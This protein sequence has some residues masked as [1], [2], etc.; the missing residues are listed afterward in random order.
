LLRVPEQ[1]FLTGWQK[2]SPP[3]AGQENHPDPS[4]RRLGDPGGPRKAAGFPRLV[5]DRGPAGPFPQAHRRS[6]PDPAGAVRGLWPPA[7]PWHGYRA[8]GAMAPA[9]PCRARRRKGFLFSCQQPMRLPLFQH[10]GYT[11]ST[12]FRC[13]RMISTPASPFSAVARGAVS[14]HQPRF[15]PSRPISTVSGASASIS[16]VS[17]S[18]AWSKG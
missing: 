2:A 12:A 3:L 15:S 5:R 4:Q 10:P 11:P 16:P 13:A 1:P 17:P 9:R 6:V 18:P 8:A 7:D 14:V